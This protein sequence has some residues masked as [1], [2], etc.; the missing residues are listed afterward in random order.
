MSTS[1]CWR[2]PRGVAGKGLAKMRGPTPTSNWYN[3]GALASAV[4]SARVH[5]CTRVRIHAARAHTRSVHTSFLE[6]LYTE[7][8]KTGSCPAESSSGVTQLFQ[9]TTRFC[10]IRNDSECV[11]Q[12]NVNCATKI[13]QGSHRT[14]VEASR[15]RLSPGKQHALGCEQRQIKGKGAGNQ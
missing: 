11:S 12:A 2:I 1:S 7:N 9:R 10:T 6:S 5:V 4:C 14:A 15:E 13:V 3:T 8:F